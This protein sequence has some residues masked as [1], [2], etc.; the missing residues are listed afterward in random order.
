MNYI[1]KMINCTG[2]GMDVRKIGDTVYVH[3][4]EDGQVLFYSPY[5]R[6]LKLPFFSKIVSGIDEA[7]KYAT[8][9]STTNFDVRGAWDSMMSERYW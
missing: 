7:R 8:C 3:I 6:K 9:I 2:Y 1:A 5:D 4:F